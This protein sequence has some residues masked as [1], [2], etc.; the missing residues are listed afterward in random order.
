MSDAWSA[1][2]SGAAP[3][4][5]TEAGNFPFDASA[6]F[7]TLFD[8]A[9][10]RWK[11]HVVNLSAAA[12]IFYVAIGASSFA[13]SFVSQVVTTV[14]AT[15]DAD[16][17]VAVL[18]GAAIS[19]IV[20]TAGSTIATTLFI[21][22][23]Y[24]MIIDALTGRPVSLGTLIL[25]FTKLLRLFAAQIALSMISLTVVAIIALPTAGAMLARGITLDEAGVEQVVMDP[26]TLGVLLVGTLA[27]LVAGLLLLPISMFTIPEIVVSDAGP[28]EAM[29][30]AWQIGSG[31]RLRIVGYSLVAGLV[32]TVGLLA[33]CVGVIPA[34]P[35]AYAVTLA[36]FLALRAGT[37]ARSAA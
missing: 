7:S 23:I 1:P 11:E 30:R 12:L 8:Y 27:G 24:G 6:D 21:G 26:V 2:E 35:L 10:E 19:Q 32:S 34:T 14:M 18:I 31:Q 25:P 22:G 5:P 20:S 36:L 17:Q 37:T 33:C 4:P 29:A 3:P 13:S 15:S 16:A 28:F 9:L